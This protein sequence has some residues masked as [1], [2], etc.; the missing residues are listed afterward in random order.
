MIYIGI[1]TGVKTGLAVWSCRAQKFLEIKTLKLHQAMRSVRQYK[2][3][4]EAGFYKGLIVRFEDARL[5][6]W[7][8]SNSNTKLQGAGSI[9][10][11]AKIWEDYLTD[12]MITF[13]AVA[14]AKGMT[15]MS[16]DPFKALT[17]WQEKTSEHSR[18]AALLVFGL[19]NKNEI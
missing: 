8:G 5:R 4:A 14:P 2:T 12:M 1:D 13:E 19:K 3:A 7:Y 9:K 16:P 18:D 15:K 17:K 6:K 10:R 11:D